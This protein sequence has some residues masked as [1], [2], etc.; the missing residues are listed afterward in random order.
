MLHTKRWYYLRVKIAELEALHYC[1]RMK[2]TNPIKMAVRRE[3]LRA[4]TGLEL[5][6][7]AGGGDAVARTDSCAAVCPGAIVA[8]TTV[9]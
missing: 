9:G 3:T 5:T 6:H 8:P 2:K 7:V 4:L 1:L